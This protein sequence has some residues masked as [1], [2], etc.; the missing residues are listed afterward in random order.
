[1]ENDQTIK[2]IA[3][4]DAESLGNADWE[5]VTEGVIIELPDGT[6]WRRMELGFTAHD[7]ALREAEFKRENGGISRSEAQEAELKAI[8]NGLPEPIFDWEHDSKYHDVF[9][10]IDGIGFY[11]LECGTAWT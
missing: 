7:E 9:E 4:V 3:L 5:A 10:R 8:E 1:M 2:L 6:K 11:C